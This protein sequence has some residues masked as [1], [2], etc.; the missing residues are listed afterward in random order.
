MSHPGPGINKH[1]SNDKIGA[2]LQDIMHDYKLYGAQILWK[3]SLNWWSIIPQM[4]TEWTKSLSNGSLDVSQTCLKY[5]A[6]TLKS[7][8]I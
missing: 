3:E 5:L 6:A 1:Y 8:D 2:M 7:T 4:P